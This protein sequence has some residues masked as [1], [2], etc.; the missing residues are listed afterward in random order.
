VVILPT[1]CVH[2][3]LV[4]KK[5]QNKIACMLHIPYA[6]GDKHMCKCEGASKRRTPLFYVWLF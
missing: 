6:S 1:R 4:A 5:A 3:T 2:H